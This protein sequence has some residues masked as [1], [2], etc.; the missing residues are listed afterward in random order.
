[1]STVLKDIIPVFMLSTSICCVSTLPGMRS[2]QWSQINVHLFPHLETGLERKSDEKATV[3][4]RQT[5]EQTSVTQME[6][7]AFE[8][9]LC[10]RFFSALKGVNRVV[11]LQ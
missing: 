5:P 8:F 10:L 7:C 2:A 1:M 3:R 6:K 4:Q 9:K 11:E